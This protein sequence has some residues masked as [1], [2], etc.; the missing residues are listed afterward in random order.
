M[1]GGA[2]IGGFRASAV[3]A[4]FSDAIVFATAG[5]SVTALPASSMPRLYPHHLGI[6]RGLHL[7]DL[8]AHRLKL[9]FA[10][11]RIELGFEVVGMAADHA[12][13][14]AERPH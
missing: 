13:I 3:S 5:A 10:H 14:L 1:R 11:R 9:G 4:D 2:G 7:L 6:D 12:G 8:F